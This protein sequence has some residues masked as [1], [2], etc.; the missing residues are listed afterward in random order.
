MEYSLYKL[1][2]LTG[3]ENRVEMLPVLRQELALVQRNAHASSIMIMDLDHFKRINDTHGHVVGDSVLAT[4]VR[5]AKTILRP[6]DRIF[7]YG[8]EEFLVLLP[9]T[10][11]DEAQ[12]VAERIR[13]ALHD[14]VLAHDHEV[15]V[16]I[17]TSA[18]VGLL[19]P[20]LTVEESITRADTALYA[21]KQGGRNQVRVS[22]PAS[23]FTAGTA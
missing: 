9:Q 18:G 17:T 2:P 8:G 7:R 10:S 6:Y 5:Y 3:A 16:S 22:A 20:N 19:E 15:A 4:A 11:L 21:A 14:Q 13:E 23:P 12:A 1:D